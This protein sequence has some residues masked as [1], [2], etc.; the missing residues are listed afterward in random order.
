MTISAAIVVPV[1][2][3]RLAWWEEIALRQVQ[4]VFR[5]QPIVFIMPEGTDYDYLPKES[6]N[7]QR[8]YFS[9][10][11]FTGIE[12]YNKL[13]MSLEFYRAFDFYDYILIYH[14]DAFVFSD[15]LN[16]FCSMGYDYIGAP[17]PFHCGHQPD[18]Y[19][20]NVFLHVGNGGFSLRKVNSF[21]DLLSKHTAQVEAWQHNEDAFFSYCGKYGN[22]GFKLAPINVAYQFSWEHDP[23]RCARKT[24]GVLPFG[25]HAW[26][27]YAADLYV[28]AFALAG[29]DLSPVYHMMLSL[30]STNKLH[31]LYEAAYARLNLRVRHQ[32][33]IGIYLPRDRTWHIFA[34]GEY[35]KTLLKMLLSEGETVES[36]HCFE[37]QEIN[38]LAQE[39]KKTNGSN[40]LILRLQDDGLLIELKKHGLQVGHEYQSFWQYYIAYVGG[41][42]RKMTC[43]NGENNDV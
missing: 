1:Y 33:K 39:I 32:R 36:I 20:E 21:V 8:V 18:V 29:C 5:R 35:G 2:K 25:C 4:K 12:G 9:S 24:K 11:F 13:M 31:H 3:V 42:L 28:K 27:R 37:E 38:S 14:L 6:W 17:W 15:K 40:N 7:F 19:G 43:A 10:R 30:D 16:Y 22:M 34:V 41:I 26:F 23:Y